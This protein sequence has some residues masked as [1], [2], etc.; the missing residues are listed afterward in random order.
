[1]W[2]GAPCAA[3]NGVTAGNRAWEFAATLLSHVFLWPVGAAWCGV[4]C[5][6]KGRLTKWPGPTKWPRRTSPTT[7][8]RVGSRSVARTPYVRR[9]YSVRAAHQLRTCG[10]PTP[11]VR[12][13][14]L[15][16][17]AHVGSLCAHVRLAVRSR[18]R[19]C[20]STASARARWAL[21][22]ISL[23][24]RV[25]SCKA[26]KNMRIPYTA[27]LQPSRRSSSP[28]RRAEYL[29]HQT[30]PSVGVAWCTEQSVFRALE[31]L[32]IV[33]SF[34]ALSPPRRPRILFPTP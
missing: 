3:S 21:R 30:F 11:Y 22:S 26:S 29:K 28:R 15:H 2:D 32:H 18:R 5:S 20:A 17:C 4:V 16:T 8:A 9:T 34:G 7:C 23:A 10:A 31:F 27:E 13:T 12:R 6:R 1:M 19:T 25:H 33:H 14:W 24:G